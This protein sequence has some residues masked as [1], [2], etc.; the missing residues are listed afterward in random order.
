MARCGD[1]IRLVDALDAVLELL[2]KIH[3]LKEPQFWG[4][5]AIREDFPKYC[6]VQ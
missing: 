2:V 3:R 1:A 5:S 6:T 4:E